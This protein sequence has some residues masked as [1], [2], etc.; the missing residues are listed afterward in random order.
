MTVYE[1]VALMKRL[2]LLPYQELPA[3]HLRAV[4]A[5]WRGPGQN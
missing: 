5:R 4:W 2:R 3:S 1:I